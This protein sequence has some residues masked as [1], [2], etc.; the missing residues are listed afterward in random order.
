MGQYIQDRQFERS[1]IN[2]SFEE[3]NKKL[4]EK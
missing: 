4:I 2:L 3:K 1:L